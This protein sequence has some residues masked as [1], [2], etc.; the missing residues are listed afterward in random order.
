MGERLLGNRKILGKN[1]SGPTK[2]VQGDIWCSLPIPTTKHVPMHI[3]VCRHLCLD[4][5]K[6]MMGGRRHIAAGE[7]LC[8]FVVK[9]VVPHVVVP[10]MQCIMLDLY[11]A[12]TPELQP[13]FKK[14]RE[15][16]FGPLDQ[17]R[18]ALHGRLSS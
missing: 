3:A 2:P 1:V 5:I 15:A 10:L 13:W 18:T 17:A 16:R 7:S 8:C 4:A 12:Q 9:S 11:N 14:T 6:S